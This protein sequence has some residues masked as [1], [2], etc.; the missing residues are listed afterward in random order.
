MVTGREADSS[1]NLGIESLPE[2]SNEFGPQS[3]TMSLG[4]QSRQKTWNKTAI[5][6]VEGILDN[7]M[8]FI[9]FEKLIHY[10]KDS[11][12]TFKKG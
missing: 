1:P 8:K 11:D 6:F 10:R 4:R 3:D 5:S 7:R 12:V 9:I 2:L